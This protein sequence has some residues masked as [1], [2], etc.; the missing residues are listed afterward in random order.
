MLGVQALLALLGADHLGLEHRELGARLRAPVLGLRERLA[1]PPDLGLRG[2]DARALRRDLPRE[3]RETLAAVR[4]TAQQ[5]RDGSL[6]LA[7]GLLGVLPV[8]DRGGE[9]VPRAGDLRLELGLRRAHAL[10]LR[11]ELVRVLPAGAASGA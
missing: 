3:P 4:G 7:R 8:G 6:G 2:L 11:L 5:R 1:Q 9:R 10:R